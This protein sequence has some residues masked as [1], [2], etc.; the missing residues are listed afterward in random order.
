MA[1][2]PYKKKKVQPSESMQPACK[3]GALLSDEDRK[4]L[5]QAMADVDPLSHKK[6]KMQLARLKE[7]PS[8]VRLRQQRAAQ[9]ATPAPEPDLLSTLHLE[10]VQPDAYV[11][12]CGPDM[13]H[14]QMRKLRLGKGEVEDTLDLHGYNFEQARTLL[15]QFVAFCRGQ[16]YTTVRVIHG[17]SHSVWGRKKS[18]KSHVYTWLK[19]I[20]QVKGFA[21]CLPVDGGT[22]AVYVLLKKQR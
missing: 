14:H 16:G 22:G 7:L 18:M 1:N 10:E 19:Q 12:H 21:S 15:K 6:A 20:E 8:T 3:T 2:P 17:K 5:Q 4:L 9:M 11:E 13:T